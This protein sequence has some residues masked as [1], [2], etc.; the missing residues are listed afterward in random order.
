MTTS[1][2]AQRF[3]NVI[4]VIYQSVNSV[5]NDY[6]ISATYNPPV[7]LQTRPSSSQFVINLYNTAG[8]NKLA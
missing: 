1:L 3:N 8:A 7:Y 6:N 2:S 4:G 5:D